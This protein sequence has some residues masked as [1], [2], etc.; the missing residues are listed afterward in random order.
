MVDASGRRL[1]WTL[2][3]PIHTFFCAP[4]IGGIVLSREIRTCMKMSGVGD[5]EGL[6]R[7]PD[8]LIGLQVA[9]AIADDVVAV[10]TITDTA[11]DLNASAFPVHINAD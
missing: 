1:Y 11:P 8:F 5:I 10:L 2:E 7:S 4:G 9:V 3:E 6:I